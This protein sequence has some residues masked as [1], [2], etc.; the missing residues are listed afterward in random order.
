MSTIL[1][2]VTNDPQFSLLADMVQQAD[3]E[4]LGLGGILDANRFDFTLFA[5]TNEAI[6]N[7]ANAIGYPDPDPNGASAYVLAAMNSLTGGNAV[8][9][10]SQILVLHVAPGIFSAEQLND[11]NLGPIVTIQGTPLTVSGGR[12]VDGDPDNDDANVLAL[13]TADNGNVIAIDQLLLPIDLDPSPEPTMGG[14]LIVGGPLDD[15]FFL[16]DGDDVASGGDG[17]DIIHGGDGNDLIHGGRG[18][19]YLTGG[20]GDD[21]LE[22]QKGDDRL[23]G[24]RGDDVLNGDQ[25][26]DTLRGGAGDDVLQGG[27]GNDFLSGNSGDDKLRGGNGDDILYGR[28]GTDRLN[29]GQG[30]DELYGGD[31]RDHLFGGSGDDYVD[32]G[33]GD[34]FVAGGVGDDIVIGGNGDDYVKGNT[35]DDWL[36]GGEGDNTFE[37]NE[38]A[39]I[40]SFDYQSGAN[41]IVDFTPGEDKLE[42]APTGPNGG[43]FFD[44]NQGDGNDLLIT[45]NLNDEWSVLVLDS[46]MVDIEDLLLA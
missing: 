12:I 21:R 19:D 6:V 26:D 31:G 15:T 18:N 1:E 27:S 4:G 5:P 7:L 22:G 16:L 37:G 35:G 24:G 3:A 23:F 32:G 10:M 8:A 29:G 34:D 30:E 46:E 33:D 42:F 20:N 9:L 28:S 11:P 13:L 44:V 38:G 2:I 41:V 39:D 14:D 17:D 45:S 36:F 40:F 43:L 25:G